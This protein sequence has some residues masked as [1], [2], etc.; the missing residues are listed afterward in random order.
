MK[1]PGLASLSRLVRLAWTGCQYLLYPPLCYL[2]GRPVVLEEHP[3]CAA[4]RREVLHDPLAACPRCAATVGPY[5][6]VAGRCPACRHESFAFERALRLGPY[7]ELREI[8]L[9][10]KQRHWEGLAEVLGEQWA[11]QAAAALAALKAELIVPVPLHWRR[12]LWRGYNQS[13]ALAR[14]LAARMGLPCRSGELRRIRHTPFQTRQT[15]AGRRDN[16]RGAFAPSRRAR[17]Q[18]RHVLL[19]DDVMTT[20]A[21]VHE[22][23][24]ALRAAGAARV[25]VAVLARGHG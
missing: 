18:G 14:G 12:L 20:G 24:R 17:V 21:T 8:V 11:L 25:S 13:A 9:R 1:T 15:L 2:C 3:F 16:V 19:V 23:A 6:V 10:L 22:A 4:C 7:E 5:G